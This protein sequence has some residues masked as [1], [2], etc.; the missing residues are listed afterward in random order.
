[1]YR[2][3][4]SVYLPMV[5][6]LL[7]AEQMDLVFLRCNCFAKSIFGLLEPSI[8]LK[9]DNSIG[10]YLAFYMES[11]NINP[12]KFVTE[13]RQSRIFWTEQQKFVSVLIL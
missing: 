9:L 10:I 5:N 1:M 13:Y 6:K 8:H 3:G 12:V 4:L 2:K 11:I 7:S